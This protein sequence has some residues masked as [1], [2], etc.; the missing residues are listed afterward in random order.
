MKQPITQRESGKRSNHRVAWALR[1]L[2]S[3]ALGWQ[4][5]SLQVIRWSSY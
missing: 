3:R 5:C 4:R 1:Q 2:A